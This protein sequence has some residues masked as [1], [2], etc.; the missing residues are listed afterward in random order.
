MNF[1]ERIE[2]KRNINRSTEET[3]RSI[4][5]PV[6]VG[7]GAVLGYCLMAGLVAML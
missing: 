7:F 1:S 3:I 5:R 2:M 6:L 4:I